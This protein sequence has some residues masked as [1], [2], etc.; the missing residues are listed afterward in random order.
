MGLAQWLVNKQKQK[1]MLF[2]LLQT[3][4]AATVADS[5]AEAAPA[6]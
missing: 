2:H 1:Y 3:D 4:I 6:A 5:L